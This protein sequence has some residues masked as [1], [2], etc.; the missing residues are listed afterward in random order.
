MT[1]IVT[2]FCSTGSFRLR[3]LQ[4]PL[5]ISCFLTLTTFQTH[6]VLSEESRQ[7]HFY[8]IDTPDRHQRQ[9]HRPLG[10]VDATWH[11]RFRLS[12]TITVVVWRQEH[13]G[14]ASWIRFKTITSLHFTLWCRC[15][16][17]CSV[18]TMTPIQHGTAPASLGH[19][20]L[21]LGHP[22][23]GTNSTQLGIV[24]ALTQTRNCTQLEIVVFR[25][26]HRFDWTIDYIV[27]ISTFAL[28]YLRP[29]A[30]CWPHDNEVFV[31]FFCC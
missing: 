2:E 12:D 8:E 27:T 15:D 11:L 5:P 9:S 28:F 29:L 23:L 13:N 31:T 10:D 30:R 22:P 4:N 14:M 25:K 26:C 20:L 21:L 16:G 19:P 18:D 24:S 1:E 7:L 17:I 6:V 3:T